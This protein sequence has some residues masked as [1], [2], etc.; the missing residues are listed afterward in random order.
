MF[1]KTAKDASPA[2]PAPS[3]PKPEVAYAPSE[4][5]ASRKP[6]PASLI[7][8]N[9][10]L[11]GGLTGEGE[12]HVDGVIR[13]TVRVAKLSIGETGHIEGAIHADSVEVRGRVLGEVSAKQVKLY[14]TAHVDGDITH[15]QLSMEIGAFFQ[16]RSL[17]FQ[18]PAAQA[19]PAQVIEALPSAKTLDAEPAGERQAVM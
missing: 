16:G 3:R 14:A 17:R 1:A 12:L 13:G 9:M 2:S 15:E 10:T 11:E 4:A 7:S 8:E 19:V 18:R 6:M 5:P